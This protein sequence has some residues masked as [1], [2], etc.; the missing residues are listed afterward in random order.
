[1]EYGKQFKYYTST[2]NGTILLDMITCARVEQLI[3]L[4]ELNFV[5]VTQLQ[6]VFSQRHCYQYILTLFPLKLLAFF[7]HNVRYLKYFLI[8]FSGDQ[9]SRFFFFELQSGHQSLV[10]QL[11][12]GCCFCK[13]QQEFKKKRRMGIVHYY[14]CIWPFF[15]PFYRYFHSL[16]WI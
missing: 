2:P 10:Y 6:Y 13:L 3:W 14:Y 11:Q 4:V 7:Y 15:S 9:K 8:Q 16:R 12:L 1:M 5:A